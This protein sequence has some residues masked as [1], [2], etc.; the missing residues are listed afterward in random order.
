[1]EVQR[2]LGSDIQM[3]LDEC[4][5]LP[6]SHEEAERAMRLSLRWAE[7]SKKR[8][9]RTA[10]PGDLRHRPGG[11]GKGPSPVQRPGARRD[12]LSRLFDRRI[13]GRR[14][15]GGDARHA[16]RRG[17][18][19]ALRQAALSD[20]RR[21]ARR[22]ASGDA[23]RRR[24]VRLRDAD[25]RRKARDRLYSPGPSQPAQCAL[26]RRSAPGRSPVLVADGARLFPRLLAPSG[27]SQARFSR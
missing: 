22:S 24:H 14:A 15:A 25:A 12:G 17:P 18:A 20:G 27:R 5:R 19:S 7:R 11:H 23:A 26:C 9:R 1:M 8:L 3:Q 2:L 4:V 10:G 6:C 16:R 13:G 21:N